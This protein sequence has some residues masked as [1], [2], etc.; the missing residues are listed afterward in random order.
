MVAYND[1]CLSLLYESSL[2]YGRVEV[3]YD[4]AILDQSPSL[5]V[6]WNARLNTVIAE[7]EEERPEE[8]PEKHGE[9]K[10]ELTYRNKAGLER[11]G[12]SGN[13]Q[14]TYFQF[15]DDD[16]VAPSDALFNY[17]YNHLI[18]STM[19]NETIVNSYEIHHLKNETIDLT[20]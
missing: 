7:K 8:C 17:R 6:F 3:V 1:T 9:F 2:K 20:E 13:R 10:I 18:I 16:Y 19:L 15:R 4:D 11:F 12:K 5:E 14:F